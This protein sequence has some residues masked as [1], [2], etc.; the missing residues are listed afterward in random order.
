MKTYRFDQLKTLWTEEHEVNWKIRLYLNINGIKFV[1]EDNKLYEEDPTIT[2]KQ[3]EE[4]E[5][6]Y[7]KDEDWQ[8]SPED[9][10]KMVRDAKALYKLSEVHIHI[11]SEDQ[12]DLLEQINYE[13]DLTV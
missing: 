2:P 10:E 13:R 11:W 4:I 1:M 8:Y 9:V 12:K 6:K 5:S 3:R 7:E